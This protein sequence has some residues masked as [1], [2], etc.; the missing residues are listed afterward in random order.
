MAELIEEQRERLVALQESTVPVVKKV[1]IWQS[2]TTAK[3]SSSELEQ[4]LSNNEIILTYKGYLVASWSYTPVGSVFKFLYIRAS[5][6]MMTLQYVGNNKVNASKAITEGGVT[7]TIPFTVNT[8]SANT[9]GAITLDI[10]DI[11]PHGTNV[12]DT[13][14]WNGSAWVIGS[15]N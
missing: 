6:D 5:N 8:K 4:M 14:Y 9:N 10:N 2:G 13:L 12:G 7:R 1:E 11:L 3:Y 15:Q